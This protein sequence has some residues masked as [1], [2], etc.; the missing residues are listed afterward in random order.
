MEWAGGPTEKNGRISNLNLNN[1]SA[2]GAA[3]GGPF[4]L[5]EL[6]KPSFQS[7]TNW[8]PR[9][10]FSYTPGSSNKFVIRGGYGVAYD[11]VFLNPITNQRFLPPLIITG[12]LTGGFTGENSYS[13]LVA[14]SS[15]LHSQ[16]KA[17]VGNLSQTVRNF[18]A[19]SP[20]IDQGL[21]NAQVHQWNFG[22]QR[23]VAGLILK[24]AYV[25]TKGNYLPRT[26]SINLIARPPAPATSLADE[27][28]RLA[29]FRAAFAGASGGATAVSNRIDPR[30]NEI[31]YVNSSAN[32]NYHSGQFEV[33]K[34]F[35]AGYMFN[36]A[37]TVGKSIDDNSDVL[38]VL[39][40][41]SAS[42]QN[43]LNNRDNRGLSQFDIP[44]RLAISHN[45]VTPW[46]K[47]SSS[48]LVRTLL[49]EWGFAGISSFRS[50]FP[51][52][53]D[54]GSRRGIRASTMTGIING[55]VRPNATGTVNFQPKPSGSAGAPFGT[56][57]DAIQALSSY[58]VSLGLSQPLLGNYGGLGRASNRLDGETNFDWTIYKNIPVTEGT[59][60]QFQAQFINATNSASFQDV[61]FTISSP[62]F[63]Q[64]LTSTSNGRFIQLGGRFVF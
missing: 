8:G 21:S 53:F 13:R 63:G 45:W 20:A 61:D 43:P 39:I 30:Y 37:Y 47:S 44:Q 38:G 51:V 48:R 18:G 7:N 62:S 26:Q 40:N 35:S 29:E 58:A 19:I 64:Y 17:Q 28:A 6:G 54:T 60:F 56:N 3:G 52:T 11:F 46:G 10:G 2:F 42:Q 57:G 23:D 59:Y 22:I 4:G 16:T 33:Q 24:A 41:D 34:R 15:L 1:N 50:G 5:L 27:T 49:A 14:G 9:V 32:S 25:G 55:P 12:V 31:N 36:V